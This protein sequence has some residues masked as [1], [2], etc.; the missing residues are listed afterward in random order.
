MT[1]PDQN[2]E[3]YRDSCLEDMTTLQ[4]E[5]MK[6][7]DINSYENWFY[8]HNIGAFHFKSDDGRNLYFK[9]VDVGSF[10]IKANTWNWS[11]NNQSTPLHIS[12]PLKKVKEVGLANN[13]TELT[14][15]LFNGDDYT[16]WELTAVSAKILNAIG[17][18]RVPQDQ[19]FIYF[20]FTSEL[21]QQDYE[22]LKEKYIKCDVHN[23][24]RVAFICRHL[25]K[26]KY[27][28]FHESVESD[29]MTDDDDYQAW[30]DECEK[31]REQ[32]GEWNDTSM[33]FAKIKLVCDQCYF[34][35]KE[36]N[37]HIENGPRFF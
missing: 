19:L 4:N 11:W 15:G 1:P 35:I 30:C 3:S 12:R 5:F 6:L 17:A 26:D 28:G 2:F 21:T 7:Y 29:I 36:K 33:T 22:A 32:E 18:Y 27:T 20:I 25:N 10:S 8:D 31:V 23:S 13:F 37:N 9:Y 34:E 16:G 24:G 14:Q